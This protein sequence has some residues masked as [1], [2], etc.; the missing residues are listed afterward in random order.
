VCRLAG[1]E[2]VVLLVGYA[3]RSE[4]HDLTQRIKGALVEPMAVAGSTVQMG[5]SIGAV[6]VTRDD[7]RDAAT[8]LREADRAMYA[9]KAS[10]RRTVVHSPDQLGVDSAHTPGFESS[11][12]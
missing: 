10:G 1:D 5:A 3:C 7:P 2:F 11:R 12:P 4:L 9:A 8:L 6:E